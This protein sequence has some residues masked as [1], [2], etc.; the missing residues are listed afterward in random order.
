MTPDQTIDTLLRASEQGAETRFEAWVAV[1]RELLGGELERVENEL[2]DHLGESIYPLVETG[3]HLLKAGGKRIRPILTLLGARIVGKSGAHARALA[4][5]G[6]LVHLSTLLHDDVIDDADVRRGSPTPR[7]VWSNTAS[8]LGGD[9]ALTRALELVGSAPRREP[10]DEAIVT[11][12]L[13]VEGEILQLGH[14]GRATMTLEDYD[15]LI[16]RK[17]ASLFRWCCRAGAWL[18]DDE[19]VVESLGTYGHHL[20]LC[21]QIVDDILDFSGDANGFGKQL[22]TDVND[23]KLTLPVL[24]AMDRDA[25]L[26]AHVVAAA[27]GSNGVDLAE[28]VPRA[29]EATGALKAARAVGLEHAEAACA[30]LESLPDSPWR[31]ALDSIATALAHRVR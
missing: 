20:G 3:R 7:V 26:R 14:R 18:G 9:Y 6:E 29:L 22:L 16:D 11:L 19:A 2:P 1:L 4:S 17:T 30:A 24:I 12:R 27:E 31:Q 8:V 23:G 25:D 13:L 28:L 21:F 5:A 10:L 15:A